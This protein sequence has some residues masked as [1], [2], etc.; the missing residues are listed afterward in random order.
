MCEIKEALK[1]FAE[2]ADVA[3]H[4]GAPNANSCLYG[5]ED[6][7]LIVGDF[8][9]A[10]EAFNDLNDP[11]NAK[12]AKEFKAL[13]EGISDV[14]T[15][16]GATDGVLWQANYDGFG[17]PEQQM[18]GDTSP[19]IAEFMAFCLNHREKLL[20]AFELYGK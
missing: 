14:S 16:C 17:N 13:A 12:L 2:M 11:N 7:I 3:R 18:L 1:P 10:K 19:D 15:L 20:R 8:D 6:K 9:K 4:P 5:R